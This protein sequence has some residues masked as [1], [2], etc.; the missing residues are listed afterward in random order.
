MLDFSET[1]F[2]DEGKFPC[3][4]HNESFLSEMSIWPVSALISAMRELYL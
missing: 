4:M 2:W 1:K 3:F